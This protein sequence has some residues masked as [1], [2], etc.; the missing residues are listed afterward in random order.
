MGADGGVLRMM[1]EMEVQ[2]KR[3]AGKQIKTLRDTVR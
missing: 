3:K 2:G 1:K